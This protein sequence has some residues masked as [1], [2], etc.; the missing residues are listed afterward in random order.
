LKIWGRLWIR[1]IVWRKKEHAE[2]GQLASFRKGSLAKVRYKKADQKIS[3]DNIRTKITEVVP[4][5]V[6]FASVLPLAA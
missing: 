2:V 3:A 4:M 6:G 1:L 5:N